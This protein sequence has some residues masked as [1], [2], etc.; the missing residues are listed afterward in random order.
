MVL[1]YLMIM[2]SDNGCFPKMI[3]AF[4]PSLLVPKNCYQFFFGVSTRL[5]DNRM[6]NFELL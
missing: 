4:R 6:E 3:I 2:F 1:C 5:Q